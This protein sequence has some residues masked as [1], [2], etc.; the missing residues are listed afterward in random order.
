MS[1]CWRWKSQ[2]VDNTCWSRWM[3]AKNH[4][5]TIVIAER[6]LEVYGRQPIESYRPLYHELMAKSI[7]RQ[8]FIAQLWF[9]WSS[10][11]KSGTYAVS[12]K[13]RVNKREIKSLLWI[14]V[15]QLSRESQPRC[16]RGEQSI[17]FPFQLRSL[18][19][20]YINIYGWKP[21]DQMF[22]PV[23][24]AISKNSTLLWRA[25]LLFPLRANSKLQILISF[26]H[27]ISTEKSLLFSGFRSRCVVIVH[28]RCFLSSSSFQFNWMPSHSHG[29]PIKTIEQVGSWYKSS[30]C[31]SDP[32]VTVLNMKLSGSIIFSSR[33]F[34]SSKSKKTR[35]PK[36]RPQSSTSIRF[37]NL[38]AQKSAP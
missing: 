21:V 29:K 19:L 15:T 16:T 2:Q 30:F 13:S 14:P 38:I 35:T 36:K 4:S 25:K 6:L 10:S 7:W 12:A 26:R 17:K 1:V 24:T 27:T 33:W 31:W 5:R 22:L 23:R 9:S 28:D 18:E 11:N 8:D 34:W 3:N 37:L 32:T 20:E